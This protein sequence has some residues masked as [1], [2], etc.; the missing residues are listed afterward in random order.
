MPADNADGAGQGLGGDTY[1]Y[2]AYHGYWP[3]KLDQVESRLGTEEE[4]KGLVDAAHA[5][6]VKVII[7]YVMNHV[8]DSSPVYQE[9]PEWFWPQNLANGNS[10]LCGTA[11]CPW[12]GEPG[13]R[14]WF[15]PY[16]PD[17][18]FTK[19]EARAFSVDNAI[20]WAERLGIDGFRLDAVKHIEDQWLFDLRAR[21]RAE[22]EPAL[23]EHFYMVGETFTGDKNLINRYVN[24]CSMLDGQFDFPWRM[25]VTAKLLM[26]KGKMKDLEGFLAANENS[27][28]GGRAVMSTFLGNHD[29]PRVVHFAENTPLWGSEWD[30]GKDRNWNNVPPSPAGLEAYE[31]LAVGFTLLLTTKGAPLIY[32]GDEYG[33]AGAG[34]PDNRRFMQWSGYNAGQLKL[35]AHIKKLTALRAQH[36]AMRRGTR[37]PIG[38]AADETL[39]FAL[40]ADGD[41]VIVALN[42]ADTP[43]TVSGV[44]AGNYVDALT[45]A[46]VN[47]GAA[48]TVPARGSLVLVPKP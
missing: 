23:G 33:M 46:A 39:A 24:P 5:K 27:Y 15:T 42:R 6:G 47:G 8:H 22:L 37:T 20:A 19:P 31:R 18:D 1:Q 48:V 35:N 41:S 11:A 9:H 3:S 10:C 16:L 17:F 40:Q 30:G 28:G 7:D 29:I 32:Y 13:R 38:P 21:V 36:P 2:S 34:D 14:C 43:Q 26:R 12:D 44:P 25:E 45:G 4:L